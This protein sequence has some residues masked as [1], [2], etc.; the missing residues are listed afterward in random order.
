[1]KSKI[2][3][4]IIGAKGLLA[5][6]LIKIFETDCGVI[7]ATRDDFDVGDEAAVKRFVDFH[8]P[9]IIINTA[10]FTKVDECERDPKKSFEV[11]GIGAY[12]VAAAAKA[13]GAINI[14]IST[15]YV[16]DG[17]KKSFSENDV[18]NPL[19]IYGASKLAGEI[20]TKTVGGDYYIIRTS[21]LYGVRRKDSVF[22]AQVINSAKIGEPI[23]VVD[24]QFGTPT[25]TLDLARKIKELIDKKAP[26][27]IYHI[28]DSG[29]CSW[30]EF[31]EKILELSG[32]DAELIAIKLAE[33]SPIIKKPKHSVLRS[34][35]LEKIGIQK[36]RNWQEALEDYL[37]FYKD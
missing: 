2:K 8:K 28:T 27:G 10:A 18:P 11:N 34:E 1:M 36:L 14:Y 9:E 24:D 15:N 30:Y 16:F 12:N 35:N 13:A 6:D 21:W 29:S 37:T 20:L 31:A 23:K 4:L 3:V 7:G 22:I 17:N 19:N 33:R 25:Y 26:S 5:F 32:L